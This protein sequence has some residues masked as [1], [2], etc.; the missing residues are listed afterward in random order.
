MTHIEGALIDMDGTLYRGSEPI[1]GGDTAVATLREMS[2]ET[3]FLTNSATSSPEEYVARLADCGIDATTDEILSAAESTATFVADQRP[4]GTVFVVGDGAVVALDAA[5]GRRKWSVPL[6]GQRATDVAL[7]DES[8]VVGDDSGTLT[9]LGPDGTRRWTV[10]DLHPL[11]GVAT[12]GSTVH[13]VA[14]TGRH[15]ALDVADGTVLER[16]LLVERVSDQRCGWFPD[17]ERVLGLASVADELYV[18]TRSW[19]RRYP[20]PGR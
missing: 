18:P 14:H 8:V 3:R 1:S 2:V 17:T 6:G 10:E 12:T 4:D 13:A 19:F 15:Y 16:T 11:G 5:N 20:L 7:A 9:A